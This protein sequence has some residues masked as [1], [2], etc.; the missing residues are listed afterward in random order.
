MS[1][2]GFFSLDLSTKWTN[3]MEVRKVYPSADG[4]PIGS[5]QS[6]MIVTIF[7]V[8][9]NEYRLLTMIDYRRQQV[10]VVGV[11]THAE[12]SKEHWKNRL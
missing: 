10:S 7:N 12:Y 8:R 3:L 4:V 1:M 2:R 6:K 5:G 9:G 11:L